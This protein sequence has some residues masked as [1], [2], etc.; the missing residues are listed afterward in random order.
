[1]QAGG[2]YLVS[3]FTTLHYS[4][5]WQSQF[6]FREWSLGGAVSH[7]LLDRTR[8]YIEL[9]AGSWFRSDLALIPYVGLEYN[10][11]RAGFTYDFNMSG[12]NA[13]ASERRSSEFSL[14]WVAKRLTRDNRFRCP[15]F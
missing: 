9:Y 2:L 7:M 8:H 14:I 6:R 12:R 1:M 15:V 4:M 13:A 10:G 11:V 3:E 5:Q